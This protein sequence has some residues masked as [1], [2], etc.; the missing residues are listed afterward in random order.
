MHVLVRSVL[1]GAVI[2][3]LIACRAETPESEPPSPGPAAF[4]AA[5]S[6]LTADSIRM[7]LEVR[8]LALQRLDRAMAAAERRGGGAAADIEELSS[9]ERRAA[10]AAGADWKRYAAVRD[11]V[12]RLLSLQRQREDAR[13]LGLELRHARE[14]LAAQLKSSRDAASRQFLQAQIDRLTLQI[15]KLEVER[16]PTAAEVRQAELLEAVR[17]SIATQQGRLEKI[18]RRIKEQVQRSR[19]A[20]EPGPGTPGPKI[21]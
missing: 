1:V 4:P 10:E 13:V 6:E 21:N 3:G 14:D 7:F 17:V 19:G 12:G 2:L 8:E 15:E 20:V 11:E 16:E 18:Q 5:E 9:A